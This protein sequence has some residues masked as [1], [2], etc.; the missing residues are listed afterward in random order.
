[1]IAV[2]SF[3]EGREAFEKARGESCPCG[4]CGAD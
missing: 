3:R 1:V 2:L 4:T